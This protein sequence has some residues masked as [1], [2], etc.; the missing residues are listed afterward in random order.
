MVQQARALAARLHAKPGQDDAARIQQAYALLY[1]RPA[2]PDEVAFGI[3]FLQA[4]PLR[5]EQGQEL[6][7]QL[8]PWE[9]YAQVLLGANEFIYLD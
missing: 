5:D 8:S 2:T 7:G 6:K 9:Q 1:G 4:P 3:E